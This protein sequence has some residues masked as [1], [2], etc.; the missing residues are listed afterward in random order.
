MPAQK[1]R[2]V[3]VTIEAIQWTG[4]NYEEI[5]E[6]AWTGADTEVAT[7]DTEVSQLMV[8]NSEEGQWIR[9]PLDHWVIKGI[10]GEY[11][12]CSPDVFLRTYESV[13]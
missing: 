7:L 4:E 10:K 3:P 5:R 6:W 13:E 12:P 1:Y 9:C 11:Y 2:K 8:W